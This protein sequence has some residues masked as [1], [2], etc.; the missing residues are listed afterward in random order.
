MEKNEKVQ[1]GQNILEVFTL[2]QSVIFI[3]LT[4]R[5]NFFSEIIFYP[6]TLGIMRVFIFFQ[7]GTVL[8]AFNYLYLKL[9]S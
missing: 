9:I 7:N 6:D 2:F 1:S 4:S 5:F 3:E 8:K